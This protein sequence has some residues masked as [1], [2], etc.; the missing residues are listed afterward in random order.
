MKPRSVTT[1]EAAGVWGEFGALIMAA[2]SR[3]R[4]VSAQREPDWHPEH[5]D[6]LSMIGEERLRRLA[7]PAT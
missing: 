6:M 2:S 7:A 5:T 1:E 3:I 4:A